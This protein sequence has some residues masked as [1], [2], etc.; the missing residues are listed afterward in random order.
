MGAKCPKPLLDDLTTAGFAWPWHGTPESA[1]PDAGAYALLISLKKQV[2]LQRPRGA[3]RLEAGWYLYA[4]SA[5]GPGGIRARLSR[6]FRERKACHWHI[7]QLTMPASL[8]LAHDI[9][10]GDE[11]DLIA[12]L[13]ASYAFD[14]IQP[15]FGSS[16]CSFC[17]SHLL[18]WRPPET[19]P[20]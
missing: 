20:C 13:S 16:D 19:R 1:A 10:G 9:A 17:P 5:H 14:V 7:D 6:H 4:G 18:M 8:L 12:I 11:C 2:L 3:S 15:G